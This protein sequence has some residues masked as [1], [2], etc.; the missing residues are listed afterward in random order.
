MPPGV[1]GG[2]QNPLAMLAQRG[3][4]GLPDLMMKFLTFSAGVGFPELIRAIEKMRKPAD[5]G[6]GKGVGA[7]AQ[8]SPMQSVP[9]QLAQMLAARQAG[10]MNPG[11]MALGGLR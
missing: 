9:P 1:M 10:P 4:K 6:K 5:G 2:A 8:R 7:D 11:A 3:Q